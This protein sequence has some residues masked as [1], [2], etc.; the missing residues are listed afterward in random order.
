MEYASRQRH[1]KPLTGP[2]TL[3]S[4]SH[5][6]E[7]GSYSPSVGPLAATIVRQSGAFRA[8][9]NRH[10]QIDV[11][12][13]VGPNM[14]PSK[15]EIGSKRERGQNGTTVLFQIGAGAGSGTLT[16]CVLKLI[17]VG[18]LKLID[19]WKQNCESLSALS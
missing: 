9:M 3:L 11:L 8:L 10:V 7:P 1:R 6:S 5:Q 14:A 4:Y 13:R 19:R 17:D 2:P 18:N 15:S 12:E 16:D